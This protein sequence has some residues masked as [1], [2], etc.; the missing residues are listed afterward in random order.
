M[1]LFEKLRQ[2]RIEKIR[3]QIAR[4]AGSIATAIATDIH[5]HHGPYS[6][7]FGYPMACEPERYIHH[8]RDTVVDRLGELGLQDRVEYDAV[9][10]QLACSED[11]VFKFDEWPQNVKQELTIVFVR[12][13]QSQ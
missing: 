5:Q 4:Q 2:R 3:E 13:R 10:T 11:D 7:H 12:P 9:S 6:Y 1:E 8:V